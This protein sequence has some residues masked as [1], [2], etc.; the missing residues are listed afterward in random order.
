MNTILGQTAAF[1]ALGTCISSGNFQC[2]AD[3][4]CHPRLNYANVVTC[5]GAAVSTGVTES[6]VKNVLITGIQVLKIPDCDIVKTSGIPVNGIRVLYNC[7]QSMNEL[8]LSVS[9]K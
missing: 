6:T 7:D 2:S 4:P 5:H 1:A 9:F 3:L 8:S